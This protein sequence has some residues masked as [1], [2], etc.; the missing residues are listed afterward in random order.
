MS[1]LKSWLLWRRRCGDLRCWLDRRSVLPC[2]AGTWRRCYA[3]VGVVVPASA[4]QRALCKAKSCAFFRFQFRHVL[5]KCTALTPWP[6]DDADGARGINGTCWT[7][8]GTRRT[9]DKKG[10]LGVMTC[11]RILS[12]RSPS[13]TALLRALWY[14]WCSGK[15][16]CALLEHGLFRCAVRVQG[17]ERAVR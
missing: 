9:F 6:S 1:G 15:F 3:V 10:R 12:V 16:Y 13:H 7:A 5:R 4:C 8:A 17:R 11:L 14:A 2:A